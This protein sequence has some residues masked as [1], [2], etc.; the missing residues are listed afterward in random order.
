MDKERLRQFGNRVRRVAAAV[1]HYVLEG[2]AAAGNAQ[3]LWPYEA[4]HQARQEQAAEDAEKLRTERARQAYIEQ[5][6]LDFRQQID[7]YGKG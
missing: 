2:L 4:F 1:G 7:D 6:V 5:E 3:R